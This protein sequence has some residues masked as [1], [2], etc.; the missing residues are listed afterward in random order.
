MNES[1]GGPGVATEN[2]GT[3]PAGTT[4]APV[5]ANP[6]VGPRALESGESLFGR[7]DET[8]ELLNQ[9]IADRVVLMY[10]VSGA[11]KTS[12]LKAGLLPGMQARDFTVL[13]AV[14]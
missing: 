1:P 6:Y 14:Q 2:A 3:Q 12:L 11:G 9:L 8:V 10:A 5:R 7:D 4:A 13:P